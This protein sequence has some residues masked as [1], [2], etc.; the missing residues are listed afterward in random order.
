[1]KVNADIGKSRYFGV[2]AL[3]I[4]HQPPILNLFCWLL[5]SGCVN[6]D[7]PQ[8]L[9]D[10]N[11]DTVELFGRDV[12][13]TPLYER[14]LAISP[15][16]SEI[17]Y[18]AGDYRQ[19]IRC[20]V[21]LKRDNG[22]WGEKSIL[23]YSGQYQDIEPFI[24]PDGNRLF[25][26]SN[27]PLAGD[28][29]RNDY[30]IWVSN[31]D[32]DRWDTPSPVSERINT[33]GDEYYPSLTKNGHLYFTAIRPDG[34][35]LEDIFVSTW[36]NG[37]FQEPVPLDSNINSGTYEFNAYI[38]PEEDLI[39]FSSY[40]RSDGQGGGDLYFSRK[41]TNGRWVK[42]K[43]LELVNTEKLDYC[44]FIDFPRGNFYFTSERI[45]PPTIIRSFIDLENQAGQ[46]QNG[47]GD[48]YRISLDKLPF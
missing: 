23:P 7:Y 12:I 24:A 42:A 13:S 40:G 14:D 32:G 39:I 8:L 38:S 30:N 16:G 21:S 34:P 36:E 3:M 4:M 26:A 20:L 29:L 19:N 18:T 41:N 2:I 44:P 47:F 1:V 28:S 9:L 31:K 43:N 45:G 15:D 22:H 35:G 27:R 25:F 11:P 48:I 33:T 6:P 5:I 10:V 17:I 46:V 37:V